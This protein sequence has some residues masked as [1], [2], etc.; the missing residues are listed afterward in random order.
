M[1]VSGIE[2]PVFTGITARKELT[3][4]WGLPN[5]YPEQGETMFNCSRV[6]F[7]DDDRDGLPVAVWNK[8]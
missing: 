3:W 2:V 5:T 4:K 7:V 6:L 8:S 1:L